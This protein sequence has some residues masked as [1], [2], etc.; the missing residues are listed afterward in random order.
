MK[1]S[2]CKCGF[3]TLS[4]R[5]ICP[6]CGG[7]M[8]PGEWG[9][10]GR[11][12]SF[13]RLEAIPQGLTDPYNMVLVGIEKGPKLVCWTSGTLKENDEVAIS[14]VKG[15]YICSRKAGLDFKLKETS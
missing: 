7:R 8:G 13:T 10:E 6:R 3:A 15:K 1:G 5:K 14:E 9:D 11:V 2:K 12:L 4:V